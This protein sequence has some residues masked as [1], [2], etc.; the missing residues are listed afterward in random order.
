[1]KIQ[2]N[3]ADLGILRME[4]ELTGVSV[5]AL[6]VRRFFTYI[7]RQLINDE[8]YYYKLIWN[9]LDNKKF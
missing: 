3:E 4:T 8:R 1:M 7:K 2:R 9:V 5:S 6:T